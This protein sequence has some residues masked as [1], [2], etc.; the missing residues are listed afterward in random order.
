MRYLHW[1]AIEIACAMFGVASYYFFPNT[2]IAYILLAIVIISAVI[3][4]RKEFSND[5]GVEI[6][7]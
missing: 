3:S 6:H 7:G 5:K 1:V 2:V 4:I